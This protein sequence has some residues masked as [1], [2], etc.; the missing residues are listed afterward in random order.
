MF[1]FVPRYQFDINNISNI[2]FTYIHNSIII[3]NK[4][5]V[6]QQFNICEE[7][8]SIIFESIMLACLRAAM[9]VMICSAYTAVLFSLPNIGRKVSENE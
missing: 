2:Q 8:M 3:I 4:E 6:K 9:V 5:F 1:I 7:N